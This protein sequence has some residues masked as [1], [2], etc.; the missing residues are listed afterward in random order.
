MISSARQTLI[1]ILLVLG[2][3]VSVQGQTTTQKAGSASISGKVTIKGK[4][5]AGVTVLAALSGNEY[6]NFRGH[7]TRTDQTGSYRFTKLPAGT[8]KLDSVTPAL[9][10]AKQSNSVVVAEGESIEDLNLELVPGGVITG[11]ITDPD[12]EPLIG[13]LVR[14]TPVETRFERGFGLVVSLFER[15][16][17]THHQTD[18]RGIYRLFGIPPGKYRVSVGQSDFMTG[19]S[20]E[21]YKETFYPSVSDPEK[22]TAIEVKEGSETKDV[23]IVMGIGLPAET[24]RITGRVVDSETGRPIPDIRYEVT[25]TIEHQ[26]GSSVSGMGGK[27][28]NADGEFRLENA[29]PGKYTISAEPSEGSE[30]SGASISFEVIDR[31][32]TDLLIKMTKGGS[33]SGV[34]ALDGTEISPATRS[35][36][37]YATVGST[38]STSTSSARA[39]VNQDGTFRI[40][41]V[42]SGL[43]RLGVFVF[44]SDNRENFEIVRVELDGVPQ[45]DGINIKEREHVAGIRVTVKHQKLTGAIRGQ[46]KVESGELP[47]TSEL[48]IWLWP[49][50]ENLQLKPS[51]SLPRPELDA[52]GRFFVDGL[53]AGTYQLRVYGNLPG[54]TKKTEQPTQRVTVTDDT[55][56]EVTLMIKND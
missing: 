27:I 11:K 35:F 29:S 22:A 3:A 36:R 1:C 47:P 43:A 50:D 28:T 40:N 17:P 46:V 14:I 9:I 26:S 18:D 42:R 32:R 56:T 53:P 21:R 54:R 31:D 51:S 52:R 5:A 55:V 44:G 34:L 16:N 6:S 48:W 39:S 8:Y 37:L 4:P 23:D 30:M 13:E 38:D 15:S 25:R 19:R 7:R 24:F 45:P 41:G 33:L 20:R 12:G 2:I 10:P 49:L